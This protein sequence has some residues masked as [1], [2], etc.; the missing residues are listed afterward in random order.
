MH[1]TYKWFGIPPP[2]FG[3]GMVSASGDRE[4]A[5]GKSAD[6]LQR[7]ADCRDAPRAS[8]RGWNTVLSSCAGGT[9]F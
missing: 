6:G 1:Q 2:T 5:E 9:Q 7:G 3:N 8:E 4:Y